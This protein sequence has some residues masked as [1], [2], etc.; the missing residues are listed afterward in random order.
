MEKTCTRCRETKLIS[1]YYTNGRQGLYPHCKSC[2]SSD[3]GKH[4][5]IQR[6]K[7]KQKARIKVYNAAYST[8]RRAIDPAYRL[9]C[10]LR[11]RHRKVLHGIVST[12]EGLGCD[13][14]FF[15]DYL[16]S[17]WTDGMNWDNY[18]YG[19][20]K[21][22]IDHILPLTLYYTNPEL[23]PQLIHYSN[24]QPMWQIENIKKGKKVA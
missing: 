15:R 12:S 21:W 18:G 23:L 7:P 16:G 4:A 5:H 3:T 10:N 19:K 17:L 2:K 8:N 11:N 13:S 1:E 22:N 24:M 6:S 20:D 9:L 14:V